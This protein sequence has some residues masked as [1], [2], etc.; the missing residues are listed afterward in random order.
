MADKR[1]SAKDSFRIIRNVRI[2]NNDLWM[3]IVELA[4]EVAHDR[5]VLILNKIAVNDAAIVVEWRKIAD[6]N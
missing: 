4:D 6:E 5:L 2:T 1:R 3:E